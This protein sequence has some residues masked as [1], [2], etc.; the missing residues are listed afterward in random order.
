MD[1]DSVVRLLISERVKLLAW[2]RA[3]VRD[4]HLAEDILQDV[5]VV[6]VS[7][8][9]EIRDAAAFPAWARQV[10]RFKAMH[11]LRDRKHAPA[12]LDE[13]TLAMLEPCWHVY[14]DPES[15]DVKALLRECIETLSP[16]ARQLVHWRHQEKRS[17]ESSAAALGR[18]LNTIYDTHRRAYKRL[19]DCI[20]KPMAE[21]ER[22]HG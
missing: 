5:S 18:P 15:C 1:R 21:Q 14:D 13:N 12:V 17:G 16:D 10:A 3:M 4:E 6:A 22:G 11:L 8:C 20:R 19:G 2:I 9:E 7:K